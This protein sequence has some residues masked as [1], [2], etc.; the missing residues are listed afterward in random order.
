MSY[1]ARSSLVSW[2]GEYSGTRGRSSDRDSLEP[3]RLSLGGKRSDDAEK[4][5]DDGVG[6]AIG[7]VKIVFVPGPLR[8]REVAT[9]LNDRAA[10]AM[11]GVIQLDG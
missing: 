11:A 3:C 1:A 2:S 6:G 10:V 7:R 4:E 8:V 5:R 9:R